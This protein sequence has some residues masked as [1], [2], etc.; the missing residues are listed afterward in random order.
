MVLLKQNKF[1]YKLII[2]SSLFIFLGAVALIFRI[3]KQKIISNNRVGEKTN[4]PTISEPK[5]EWISYNNAK[6]NFLISYPKVWDVND[7]TD[8]FDGDWASG[9][10][11]VT[12]TS[13]GSLK[14][15]YGFSADE[16]GLVIVDGMA[17]YVKVYKKADDSWARLKDDSGGRI[18][19][20]DGFKNAQAI[21]MFIEGETY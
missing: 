5:I 20:A 13:P 6:F 19:Y 11:V 21:R 16:N 9:D 8:L 18:V 14:D 17:S 3:T 1:N 15:E 7:R 2:I 12:F 4:N 10:E